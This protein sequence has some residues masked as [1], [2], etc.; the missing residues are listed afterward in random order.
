MILC[1]ITFRETIS[2]GFSIHVPCSL[3]RKDAEKIDVS[4]YAKW[5]DAREL[6]Y[7]AIVEYRRMKN[8][9]VVA[10]FEKDRFDKYSNFARIGDGSLGRERSRAGFHRPY[11][12]DNI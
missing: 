1:I 12:E 6:I 7:Q 4:A 2:R 9:G 5:D 3:W 8:T 10:V 11:R